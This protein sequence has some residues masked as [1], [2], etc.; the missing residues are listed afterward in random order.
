[1]ISSS[2]HNHTNRSDGL[3]TAETVI[4]YA[5]DKGIQTLGFSDHGHT[6][7]FAEGSLPIDIDSYINEN[8]RLAEKYS[9]QIEIVCGI[10][11]EFDCWQDDPRIQY[12]IGSRHCTPVGNDHFAVDA[13]SENFREGLNKYYEGDWIA[14]AKDYYSRFPE[15]VGRCR[16][17]IV[18]HF[19]LIRKFNSN[20]C[21]FP[22]NSPAYKKIA[23]EAAEA[24][25]KYGV[26]FE[27]NTQCL[28]R[29][30]RPIFMPANFL[31]RF[32]LEKGYPVMISAD[33][34]DPKLLDG[35]FPQAISR[36]KSLGYKSLIVWRNGGFQEIGIDDFMI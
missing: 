25:G 1:M 19:D 3:C 31:L 12:R 32:F 23:L 26:I 6:P 24:V 16:P 8:R 29:H 30:R 33:A 36:L 27:I 17:D 14:L 13:S 15:D 10:E 9:D 5:I 35:A 18:G 2:L 11:S 28:A 34:H 20:S 4:R 22:E 7:W 21:F